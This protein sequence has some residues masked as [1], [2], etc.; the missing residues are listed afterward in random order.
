[1]NR[2][3][4]APLNCDRRRASAAA[5]IELRA[6]GCLKEDSGVRR[7]SDLQLAL[8]CVDQACVVE[9]LRRGTAELLGQLV[10]ALCAKCP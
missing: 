5:E 9:I 2:K 8:V 7:T 4:P 1:M 6:R 10:P 3:C